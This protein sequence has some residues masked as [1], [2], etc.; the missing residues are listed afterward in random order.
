M[1]EAFLALVKQRLD[2]FEEGRNSARNSSGRW[3][4]AAMNNFSSTSIDEGENDAGP[5]PVIEFC[6]LSRAFGR[7]E[8][9]KG[10]SLRVRPGSIYGLFGRNGAGKTTAIKCL[11]NLLRATSGRVRLFGMEHERDEVEIKQRLAYVPDSAAFYP[12]MTV[13]ETIDYFASF[14]KKWDEEVEKELLERFRL[15]V[16]QR[17]GAFQGADDATCAAGGDLSGAGIADFG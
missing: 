12:W 4:E 17:E 1:R 5:E 13:R 9:L 6:E 8:A 7:A 10:L 14:R 15:D 2:G 11:L 3:I 16:N